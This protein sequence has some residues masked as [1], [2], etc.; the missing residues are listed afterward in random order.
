MSHPDQYEPLSVKAHITGSDVP[1]AGKRKVR[2]TDLRTIHLT[3]GGTDGAKPLLPENKRR[4]IAEITIHSYNAADTHSSN[5]W[6]GKTQAIAKGTAAAAA[7]ADAFYIAASTPPPIFLGGSHA[8]WVA[9]DVGSTVDLMVSVAD[10][11][12]ADE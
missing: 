6:I 4:I 10:T 11:Y 12:E 3:S 7:D 8:F 9:A 1:L 2:H 5:G